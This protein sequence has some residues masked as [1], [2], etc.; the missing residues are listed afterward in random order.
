MPDIPVPP[1]RRALP[2]RTFLGTSA[3]AAGALCLPSVSPRKRR[4][5]MLGGTGWLGPAVVRAG[6]ARGHRFTL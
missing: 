5:L 1:N 2:R 6:L 3:V 4:I